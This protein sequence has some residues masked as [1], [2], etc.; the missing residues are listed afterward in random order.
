MTQNLLTISFFV[1]VIITFYYI[2]NKNFKE[3]KLGLVFVSYLQ[4][5]IISIR[6]SSFQFSYVDSFLYSA[7][8]YII[9]NQLWL[10]ILLLK[11][12]KMEDYSDKNLLKILN[13]IEGLKDLRFKL[14][15]YSR[16]DTL[17]AW[18]K[19]SGKK[20]Y[21]I[22]F[23]EDIIKK[24]TLKEKINILAHEISHVLKKHIMKKSA[25]SFV[26]LIVI[27]VISSTLN[28]YIVISALLTANIYLIGLY[29]LVSSIS[30][31]GFIVV[32]N[33]ISWWIEYQAD[34][35]AILLT[36]DFDNFK[37]AFKKIEKEKPSKDY[38]TVL[39]AIFYDHPLTNLR[40][41]R[42]KN[43]YNHNNL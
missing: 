13:K 24:F 34:R 2:K 4:G 25:L 12:R 39:N 40:I 36:K 37:S 35:N 6:V 30:Y 11:S 29:W 14:K 23:G 26:T 18:V 22:A 17:N 9:F 43:I 27:Y 5:I 20:K 8:Y 28:R 38:G 33:R 42:L 16:G 1:L 3:S 7:V 32:Y 31:I 41:E 15:R 19:P 10:I 21:T